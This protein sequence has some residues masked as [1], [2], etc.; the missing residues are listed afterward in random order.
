MS[1][2]LVKALK[3]RAETKGINYQKFIRQALEKLSAMYPV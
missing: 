2:P 1:E 3:I